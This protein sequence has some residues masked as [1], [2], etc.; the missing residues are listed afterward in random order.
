MTRK[1]IVVVAISLMLGLV[2]NVCIAWGL[3]WRVGHFSWLMQATRSQQRGPKVLWPQSPSPDWPPFPA[4]L[5]QSEI[6]AC[7]LD[8]FAFAEVTDRVV[9]PG[10]PVEIRIYEQKVLN[11]GLPFRSMKMTWQQAEVPM[12]GSNGYRQVLPEQ[13]TF[14]TGL[15]LPER[16][17]RGPIPTLLP[18]EP[19]WPAFALNTLLYGALAGALL[20]GPR[21]LR[22]GLRRRRSQC[23]RC[24]YPIGTSLTCTECGRELPRRRIQMRMPERAAAPS[25]TSP[26]QDQAEERTG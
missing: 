11:W 3:A 7:R 8:T 9:P 21:V 6:W 4:Q 10:A 23:E 17:W 13:T 14:T 16:M 22:R 26:G 25:C 20:F 1:W 24:G 19:V 15:L 12:P 2:L 18:L 5:E